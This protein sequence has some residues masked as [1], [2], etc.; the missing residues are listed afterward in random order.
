VR[1]RAAV[2]AF[3]GLLGLAGCG[4]D[5]ASEPAA[6]TGPTSIAADDGSETFIGSPQE[7]EYISDMQINKYWPDI[8]ADVL[9]DFARAVCEGYDDGA[10][11]DSIQAVMQAY[12]IPGEDAVYLDVL[13]TTNYCPEF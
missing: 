9:I 4:G 13:V 2:L 3:G 12:G 5:D 8:D 1:R 11:S 6:A 7:V 10:D